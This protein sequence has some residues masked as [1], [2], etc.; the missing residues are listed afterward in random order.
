MH[1]GYGS[2]NDYDVLKKFLNNF[3]ENKIYVF[4]AYSYGYV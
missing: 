1:H 2:E 4:P 3:G